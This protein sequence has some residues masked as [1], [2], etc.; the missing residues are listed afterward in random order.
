MKIYFFQNKSVG[1]ECWASSRRIYDFMRQH[2]MTNYAQVEQYYIQRIVNMVK[3]QSRKS[4][5][6]QEVFENGVQLAP[7]TVVHVWT[8]NW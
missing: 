2:N 1:F 3:N 7:E 4:I 5:V 8:G 6:W